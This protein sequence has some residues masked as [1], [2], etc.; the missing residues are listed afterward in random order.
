MQGLTR[1][2]DELLKEL[3]HLRSHLSSVQ[4]AESEILQVLFFFVIASLCSL[5]GAFKFHDTVHR[6]ESLRLW[7][8]RISMKIRAV[9]A[10]VPAAERSLS[11]VLFVLRAVLDDGEKRGAGKRIAGAA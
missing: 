2:R 7:A 6:S 3:Q 11:R 8:K 10:A 1:E 5:S 9:L 4:E